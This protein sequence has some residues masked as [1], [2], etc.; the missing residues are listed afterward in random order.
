MTDAADRAI[1]WAICALRVVLVLAIVGAAV[2]C[3]RGLT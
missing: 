2:Q 3:I 1:R